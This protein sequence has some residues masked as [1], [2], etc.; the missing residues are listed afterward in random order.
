[1]EESRSWREDLS[2]CTEAEREDAELAVDIVA[3]FGRLVGGSVAE[4]PFL[5][6]VNVSYRN[7][8]RESR[9]RSGDEKLDWVGVVFLRKCGRR[10]LKQDSSQDDLEPAHLR[11]VGRGDAH[12]GLLRPSRRSNPMSPKRTLPAPRHLHDRPTPPRLPNEL[13]LPRLHALLRLPKHNNDHQ[14]Q[15]PQNAQPPLQ[16]ARLAARARLG[17]APPAA[18]G[19][20]HHIPR[21][22]DA[23]PAPLIPGNIIA[24][25]QFV[26]A[27]VD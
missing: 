15:Q 27:L 6:C 10:D 7:G 14:P 1:M 26:G 25:S 23:C 13:H 3:K 19:F 11:G 22:G 21:A 9:E 20:D 17:L 8:P 5:S 18:N 16:P 4:S 2:D 12:A 24:E